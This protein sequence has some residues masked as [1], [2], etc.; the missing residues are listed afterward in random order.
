MTRKAAVDITERLEGKPLSNQR[1][2]TMA[3]KHAAHKAAA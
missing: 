3:K 2:L 1:I